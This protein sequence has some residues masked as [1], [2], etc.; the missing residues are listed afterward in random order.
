M[1]KKLLKAVLLLALVAIV[2]MLLTGPAFAALPV[3]PI[4]PDFGTGAPGGAGSNDP[5]INISI[6]GEGSDAVRIIVLMTMLTV[7]PSILLMMT[8]FTRIII[9]FSLLRNAM[10]LQ[11][12]P[13]NQVLIGLALFLSLFIMNPVI[14]QVNETAYKPY[15]DGQ[16]STQQFLD[17]AKVP[18]RDFM[19][20]QTKREDINL[21]LNL[22]NTPRPQTIDDYPMT[23]VIPAFITS[24]LKVAFT[25]GFLIFIPFLII[26]MVVS[27]ALMSMGMMMLPPITISLPFKLML[28]VLV[29]G[30]GLLI[31]TLVSTYNP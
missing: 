15:S 1:K 16:I 20:K 26:D 11:Q 2:A 24:E 6:N 10:G 9:V 5:N 23:V 4:T 7:L 13:P 18:I 22:S 17:T 21:F 29:D 27:S 28:F 12:T 3:G 30:W 14:S 25:I 8:C 19:L 31:R